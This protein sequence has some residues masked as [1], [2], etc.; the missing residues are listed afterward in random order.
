MERPKGKPETT[1]D[2]WLAISEQLLKSSGLSIEPVT[3]DS[4]FIE[5]DISTFINRVE[6]HRQQAA[7]N[8]AR[9]TLAPRLLPR[10]S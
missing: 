1:F 10:A 6:A 2:E 3:K 9:T 4:A 7:T 5:E 8:M